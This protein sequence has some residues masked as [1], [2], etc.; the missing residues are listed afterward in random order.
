MKALKPPLLA[1][2]TTTGDEDLVLGKIDLAWKLLAEA[3]TVAEA[4]HVADVAAMA[5]VYAR[6][7]QCS[8]QI[9]DAANELKIRAERLL[10]EML[11]QLPK[12]HGAKGRGKSVVPERNHTPRLEEIGVS[13]K[14]SSRS[15]KLASVPIADFEQ[16]IKERKGKG[17][18]ITTASIFRLIHPAPK[19]VRTSGSVV[20]DW[21][22]IKAKLDAIIPNDHSR[23]EIL[24][25]IIEHCRILQ[26]P[27]DRNLPTPV[28]SPQAVVTS[29]PRDQRG[30][31]AIR[32]NAHQLDP[33]V[34]VWQ[35]VSPR[36]RKR[37][38][39]VQCV[40]QSALYDISTAQMISGRE[41]SGLL[42]ELAKT[43]ASAYSALVESGDL[44]RNC[45][46]S[47]TKFF[48]KA[49]YLRPI[50]S[51]PSQNS[52]ASSHS[53]ESHAKGKP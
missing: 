8:Q 10:G 53:A 43:H 3:R 29:R 9:V 30:A 16:A 20:H 32:R 42:L 21:V 37:T 4:K 25:K 34:N 19:P 49:Y 15:Q 13:K 40:V 23:A 27:G 14:L 28:E 48:R 46:P 26:D 44:K 31:E 36:D 39:Q 41:A 38:F 24:G 7:S 52:L 11:S 35:A 17:Q 5:A 51:V 2:T 1:L 18:E 47:A 22:S 45:V 12:N 50:P 33:I 6:R